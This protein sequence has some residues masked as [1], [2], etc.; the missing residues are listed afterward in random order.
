M[1][2]ENVSIESENLSDLSEVVSET[3][4][5]DSVIDNV[6]Q[7]QFEEINL[8]LQQQ[9]TMMAQNNTNQ[10]FFIG[11]FS[12]VFVLVLLYFAIKKFL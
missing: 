10:L 3:T 2:N 5:D 1:N 12:S 8:L 4:Y 11:T 6:Y 7:E 9:I